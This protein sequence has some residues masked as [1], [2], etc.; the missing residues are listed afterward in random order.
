MSK[1]RNQRSK[2][3]SSTPQ[4]A[5]KSSLP[6]Q[7]VLVLQ[8][9][10]ALGAYQVGVFEAQHEAGIEPDW[11][12]G[13]SIG[14]INAA[15][16]V[17]NPSERRLDCLHSFWDRVTGGAINP[18]ATFDQTNV[19][20]NMVTLTR[21]IP[22]FFRSNPAIWG[23]AHVQVGV[24]SAAYYSTD[25]LRETL[26]ALVDFD[27]INAGA[28]RLT[29]VAVN[30]RSGAMR[31][32]DNRRETLALE[33]VMASCALPPAFPAVRVEGEPYRDGGIYSNTPIEAVLDDNPRR[34]SVLF[35]VTVWQPT[36]P[37]PESVWQVLARQKDIQYASRADGHIA[38]QKQIHHLRHIIREL[39]SSGPIPRRSRRK[40]DSKSA[41]FEL[42]VDTSRL[43]ARFF[44]RQVATVDPRYAAGSRTGQLRLRDHHACSTPA[45]STP[46]RRGSHQGY[47][48]HVVGRAQTRAGRV[49]GHTRHDLAGTLDAADRPDR[50]RGRALIRPLEFGRAIRRAVSSVLDSCI[51]P[52]KVCT[53][54]AMRFAPNA[55]GQ[56]SSVLIVIAASQAPNSLPGM[57]RDNERATHGSGQ[58]AALLDKLLEHDFHAL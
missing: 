8:G 44:I 9:G 2:P 35:A 56:T 34:D 49:R 41:A 52:G 55:S 16:I 24:E 29:V 3:D 22:N 51:S 40:A 7:V 28:T 48:F 33:H 17:G 6:G 32:F 27:H 5:A 11:V 45:G 37:E 43:A 13:I 20:A 4:G 18:W 38:R 54:R 36:G 21:G 19:F 10:G 23:G 47:R 26:A 39:I 14:A 46:R 50:G 25:P 15:L 31:Y 42:G 1:P 12:I 58:L 57:Q 53:R 30:V